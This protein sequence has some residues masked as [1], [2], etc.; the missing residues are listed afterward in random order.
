VD[1][2]HFDA[3]PETTYPFDA[4]PDAVPDPDFY[5]MPIWIPILIFI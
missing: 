5:L 4:D 1:P 2:H 3:D